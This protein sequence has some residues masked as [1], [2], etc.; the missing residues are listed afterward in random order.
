MTVFFPLKDRERLKLKIENVDMAVARAQNQ[1]PETYPIVD[2]I[3][4]LAYR[5]EKLK[6]AEICLT[7]FSQ[8]VRDV[9]KNWYFTNI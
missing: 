2:N 8:T 6:F 1:L 3:H 7:F 5:L 4:E 9:I